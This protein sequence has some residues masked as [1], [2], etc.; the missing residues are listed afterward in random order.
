MNDNCHTIANSGQENI[1]GDLLGDVCDIDADGDGYDDYYDDCIGPAVNWV[2][3]EWTLDRDGDG[4][5]DADEDGEDDGD[6][7]EDISD[8]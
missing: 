5:R 2:Q 7:I 8:A 1:D 3:S 4:C 6:G